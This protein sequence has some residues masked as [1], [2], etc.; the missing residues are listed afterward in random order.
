MQ[1]DQ[2]TPP[3]CKSRFRFPVRSGLITSALVAMLGLPAS[4]LAH[5]PW[6]TVH[7]DD[8]QSG[9]EYRIHTGHLFPEDQPLSADRLSGIR[10]VRPDG[11]VETLQ[12]GGTERLMLSAPL[13]GTMMLV[14]EDQPTYWSRTFEGGRAVSREQAPD[15]FSC[16]LTTSL[17]KAALGHGSGVAWRYR[18]GHALELLPL[19]DP[20]ALSPSDPLSIQVLFHGDPWEGEL[21]LTYAGFP[22]QGDDDYA[23][24]IR[25]NADGVARFVPAVAG[26][27]LVRAY[28]S[29][30]Y[31]DPAVCDRRSYYSTLTFAIR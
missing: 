8:G 13:E 9:I 31:P 28:A 7:A 3:G 11:A 17:M 30:A 18:Q 15:A 12:P 22:R 29:E 21:K 4:G 5:Y 24:T 27:W 20:A 23:L 25:T 10:L 1:D 26:Y 6:I 16:S 19:N 2:P 14:A